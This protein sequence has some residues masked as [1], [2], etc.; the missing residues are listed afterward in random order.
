MDVGALIAIGTAVGIVCGL[1]PLIFGLNRG[2]KGLAWGGFAACVL[3]GA[4]FALILALPLAII[5]AVLIQKASKRK[6]TEATAYGAVPGPG[7]PQAPAQ[8]GPESVQAAGAQPTQ[9][10][11]AP[12][13][14]Q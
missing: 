7:M 2:E 10:P 12:P 9:P 8:V 4:L 13:A 14:A 3:G 11:A 1:V 6:M 5:F